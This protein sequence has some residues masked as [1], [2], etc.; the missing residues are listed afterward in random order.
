MCQHFAHCVGKRRALRNLYLILTEHS[1]LAPKAA[2]R[3]VDLPKARRGG[4][5]FPDRTISEGSTF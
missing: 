5:T 1:A 4:G 3:A 2:L